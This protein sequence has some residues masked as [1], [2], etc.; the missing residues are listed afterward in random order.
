MFKNNMLKTCCFVHVEQKACFCGHSYFLMEI[1]WLS[2]HLPF[3][4]HCDI[5]VYLAFRRTACRRATLLIK[6]LKKNVSTERGATMVET[7]FGI[8]LFL[9]LI[10]CLFS[11]LWT[12]Y[13]YVVA[14]FLATE[15]TRELQVLKGTPANRA[16]C[17]INAISRTTTGTFNGTGCSAEVIA[18]S[19]TLKALSRLRAQNYAM[20]LNRGGTCAN[21]G[22]IRIEYWWNG[23]GWIG[24][25]GTAANAGCNG[26]FVKVTIDVDSMVHR[27]VNSAGGG[28]GVINLGGQLRYDQNVIRIKGSAIG[29]NE[30]VVN[31][32]PH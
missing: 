32:C 18:N 11:I 8:S 3:F 10:L 22:C 17:I 12:A 27:I 21:G 7:A 28:G 29:R 2:L 6:I 24:G 20:N 15:A 25:S 5:S 30:G 19:D 14:Q 9:F 1:V 31:L 16:T 23:H 13:H 26:E 4:V